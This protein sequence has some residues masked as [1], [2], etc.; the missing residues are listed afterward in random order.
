MA[1]LI[2]LLW[3]LLMDVRMAAWLESSLVVKRVLT[4]S[5]NKLVGCLAVWKASTA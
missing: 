4:S 1:A 3:V 5:A 2:A